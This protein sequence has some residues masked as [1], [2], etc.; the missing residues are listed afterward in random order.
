MPNR[1]MRPASQGYVAFPGGERLSEQDEV[2]REIG[3]ILV[4]EDLG[5]M[6]RYFAGRF[7]RSNKDWSQ[8][9]HTPIADSQGCFGPP[10]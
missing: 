9:A 1:R 7:R 5:V 2:Y 10:I 8:V 6:Y 3:I 4:Q